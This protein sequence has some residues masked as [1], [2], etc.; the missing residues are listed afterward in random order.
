MMLH[1]SR[2]ILREVLIS[3]LE[4]VHVLN[5]LPE[6]DRYNTL[7][8]PESI[9][10]TKAHLEDWLSARNQQPPAKYVFCIEDRSGN[11]VGMIGLALGRAKYRCAEIWFKLVPKH[12]NKAYASE[13]AGEIL[14]FAFNELH[15]HRVEAGCA[16]ENMASKRVLEKIGMSQEGR[17]RQKL[18][19][20]GE[21][22]D[23]FE[24]AILASDFKEI[25]AGGRG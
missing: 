15:L 3:D 16:V 13:A 20:R 10:V 11:F 14:R 7:G 22:V 2:L 18:P 24:Y 4:K 8:I 19:I 21:W 5:S 25:Q 9:E 1:T 17:C 6:T 23:N 12:W